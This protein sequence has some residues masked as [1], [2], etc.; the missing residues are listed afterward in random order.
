MHQSWG[1][2]VRPKANRFYPLHR[3]QLAVLAHVANEA[4][5]HA[6][7]CGDFNV[8]RES[9][10]FG[11][12]TEFFGE[13]LL[14]LEAH[15]GR[16]AEGVRQ[17]VRPEHGSERGDA[18]LLVSAVAEEQSLGFIYLPFGQRV[19][20]Q[21]ELGAGEAGL[22]RVGD[23][24][25]ERLDVVEAVLGLLPGGDVTVAA[26]DGDGDPVA[27]ERGQG[28]LQSDS[29]LADDLVR[30]GQ[31]LLVLVCWPTTFRSVVWAI[32]P[33]ASRTFSIATT[34]FTASTTL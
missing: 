3:A 8:A 9:P 1:A 10:L 7:V 12:F 31:L 26:P 27:I 30:M 17:L 32:W 16:A 15:V 11:E 18:Q 23:Q 28:I 20:A 21:D 22:G 5:P 34:D 19:A 29:E 24:R 13:L 2:P 14:E 4:G 33:M 6:V 25:V